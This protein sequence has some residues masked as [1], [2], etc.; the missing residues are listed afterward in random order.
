ML[1]D[2]YPDVRKLTPAEKLIFV[3]ELWDDLAEHPS[4]IP[5]SR[6]IVAEL[7]RRMEHFRQHPDEFT[8]WEAIQEKVLGKR[9]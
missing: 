2:R 9:L 5:V 3:G 8:T 4:D 1:L 6:E 7:E